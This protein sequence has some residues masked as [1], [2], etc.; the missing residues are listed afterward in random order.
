MLRTVVEREMPIQ[1][2]SLVALA[3]LKVRRINE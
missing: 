1:E 2:S 3:K